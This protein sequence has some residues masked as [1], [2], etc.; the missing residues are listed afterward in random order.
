MGL[1][2]LPLSDLSSTGFP[3]IILEQHFP[4]S[5]QFSEFPQASDSLSCSGRFNRCTG[6][7]VPE[8]FVRV[9][10]QVLG[11]EMVCFCCRTSF[12]QVLNVEFSVAAC[13]RVQ[14][15]LGEFC[16]EQG[17]HIWALF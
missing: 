10:E 1:G 7:G 5:L 8:S 13:S 6:R 17:S 16:H 15:V 2:E 14:A 12:G 11:E 3:P 9:L 4:F